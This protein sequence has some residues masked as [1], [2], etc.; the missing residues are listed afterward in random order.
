MLTEFL[1]PSFLPFVLLV[2]LLPHVLRKPLLRGRPTGHRAVNGPEFHETTIVFPMIPTRRVCAMCGNREPTAEGSALW[3]IHSWIFRHFGHRNYEMT[4][5]GT[6]TR[7]FFGI[8]PYSVAEK[9][10]F[11]RGGLVHNRHC[12]M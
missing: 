12:T 11:R 7:S 1:C 8:P 3:K 4:G 9:Q 2:F 5:L 6:A 10:H